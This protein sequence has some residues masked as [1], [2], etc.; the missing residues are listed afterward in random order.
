MRWRPPSQRG[1]RSRS[2]RLSCSC[3]G[4][5]T[6]TRASLPSRGEGCREGRSRGG[7]SQHPRTLVHPPQQASSTSSAV[8]NSS[9]TDRL[10]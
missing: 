1:V 2:C 9:R 8:I 7:A 5:A 10:I 4:R 3:C 6:P